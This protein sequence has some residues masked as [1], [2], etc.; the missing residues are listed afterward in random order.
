MRRIK[1]EGPLLCQI[2]GLLPKGR[3]FKIEGLN[4]GLGYQTCRNLRV[5]RCHPR[6]CKFFCINVRLNS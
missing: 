5:L 2:V 6:A 1:V 4:E 3:G